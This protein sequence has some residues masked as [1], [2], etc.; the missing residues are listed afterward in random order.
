MSAK[1]A[2]SE[3]DSRDLAKIKLIL[4]IEKYFPQKILDKHLNSNST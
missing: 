2:S 3:L 4:A 1:L